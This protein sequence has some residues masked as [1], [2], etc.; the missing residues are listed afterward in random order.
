[1]K[2]LSQYTNAT[3]R[4]EQ[5]S[6]WKRVHHLRAGDEILC[7]MTRP[8]FFGTT[9]V[10]AGF[11]ETWEVSQPSIWRSVL[12]IKRQHQHL[13]F[14][15]FVSGKW[16]KAGTFVLPN[17]ERIEFVQSMWKAVNELHSAQKITLVSMKR[18]SW[19]K[20][21]LQV[22]IEHPS[23]VLDRYPWIIMVAYM[24]ILERQRQTS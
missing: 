18:N 17:G 2:T 22:V 7:T 20:R 6:V 23:D 14:A 9:V 24:K 13:P 21:G 8:H 3:L 1:M 19:R 11:G 5:P 4:L 16:G 12:E 15:T 10:I